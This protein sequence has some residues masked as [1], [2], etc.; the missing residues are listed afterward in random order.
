M[1]PKDNTIDILSEDC[2]RLIF[3]C[4]TLQE[5]LSLRLVSTQWNSLVCSLFTSVRTLKVFGCDEDLEH[6]V[7]GMKNYR[8]KDTYEVQEILGT[9]IQRSVDD[10]NHDA[11]MV[12]KDEQS[13]KIACTVL[14]Q[15]F[16]N[17]QYLV[18]ACR[19]L[20]S[21]DQLPSKGF[22]VLIN[23]KTNKTL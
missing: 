22:F 14:S 16:P 23:N 5:Q 18:L 15:L 3:S 7:T 21:S 6:L 9:N 17:V 1:E 20:Y 2:F 4:L 13:A 12:K 10:F 19:Q 8:V 11:F